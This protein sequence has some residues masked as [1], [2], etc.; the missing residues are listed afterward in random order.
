M[1]FQ[2]RKSTEK[3]SGVSR[4]SICSISAGKAETCVHSSQKSRE[5]TCFSC[6]VDCTNGWRCGIEAGRVAENKVE[7]DVDVDTVKRCGH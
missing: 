3:P 2:E 4:V 6:R 7:I 5:G 1:E